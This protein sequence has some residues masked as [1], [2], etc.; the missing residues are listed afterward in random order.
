MR[1]YLSPVR[2]CDLNESPYTLHTTARRRA[3]PA[4]SRRI[5]V[6]TDQVSK[7]QGGLMLETFQFGAILSCALFAGKIDTRR[8]FVAVVYE[9]VSEFTNCSAW[10]H[11][12]PREEG[13]M[14]A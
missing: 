3:I 9:P 14:P 1:P 7:P 4:S 13:N 8:L 11:S 5:S 6:N 12:P 2:W 10:A